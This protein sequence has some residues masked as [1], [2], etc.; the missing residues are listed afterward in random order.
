MISRDKR[1]VLHG[2]LAN[3]INVRGWLLFLSAFSRERMRANLEQPSDRPQGWF[4]RPRLQ[5]LRALGDEIERDD[6]RRF[7]RS[8]GNG[9][10][11]RGSNSMTTK[12]RLPWNQ[13]LYDLVNSWARIGPLSLPL[14][15]GSGLPGFMQCCCD[16]VGRNRSLERILKTWEIDANVQYGAVVSN[17]EL[18]LWWWLSSLSESTQVPLPS[19]VMLVRSC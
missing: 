4:A 9:C 12:E 15:D 11:S 6:K 7:A 1:L 5:C 17:K 3:Y 2:R 16:R 8:F 14:T 10:S 13:I 18:A 19:S